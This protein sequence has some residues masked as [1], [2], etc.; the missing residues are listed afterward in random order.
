MYQAQTTTLSKFVDL[1]VL[2]QSNEFSKNVLL[3]C[4][5]MELEELITIFKEKK[6]YS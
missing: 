5:F 2:D 6:Y 3:I 4:T 1:F